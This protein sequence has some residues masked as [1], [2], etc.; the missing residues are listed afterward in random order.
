[1]WRHLLTQGCD[2]LFRG[3]VTKKLL[4]PS[5]VKLKKC[6]KIWFMQFKVLN[7]FYLVL[8]AK[9]NKECGMT[10]WKKTKNVVFH[11]RNPILCQLVTQSNNCLFVFREILHILLNINNQLNSMNPNVNHV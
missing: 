5:S 6:L 7:Q 10:F 1:M 9:N 11:T 3:V 4:M 2:H 8:K